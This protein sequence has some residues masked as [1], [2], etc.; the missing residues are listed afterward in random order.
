[1][2]TRAEPEAGARLTRGS[3]SNSIAALAQPNRFRILELLRTG[4]RS[5]NNIGERLRL[6]QS[7]VSTHLRVLKEAGLVDV[8]TRA[9]QRFYELRGRVP[10]S[11]PRV[12]GKIPPALGCAGGKARRFHPR[13][14]VIRA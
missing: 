14:G 8:R 4:P 11:P 2:I 10:P 7:Q 6:N 5:V 9:R 3:A 13:P 1:V 12:V